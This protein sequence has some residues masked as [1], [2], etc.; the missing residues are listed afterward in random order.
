MFL[1]LDENF[2]HKYL[3]YK[4]KYFKLKG[5]AFLDINTN[6][7]SALSNNKSQELNIGTEINKSKY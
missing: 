7:N 5:G 4:K 1:N 2:K 6:K 3:K